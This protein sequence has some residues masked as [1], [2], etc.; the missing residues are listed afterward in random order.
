MF[1][2]KKNQLSKIIKTI[3]EDAYIYKPANKIF[4]GDK[5]KTAGNYRS[6]VNSLNKFIVKKYQDYIEKIENERSRIDFKSGGAISIWY[7]PLSPFPSSMDPYYMSITLYGP[8][9]DQIKELDCR[10]GK[11][12]D[13]KEGWTYDEKTLQWFNSQQAAD[14]LIKKAISSM[15]FK[16]VLGK[17]KLI[18]N[19]DFNEVIYFLKSTKYKKNNVDRYSG[20]TAYTVYNEDYDLFTWDISPLYRK[21]KKQIVQKLILDNQENLSKVFFSKISI[22]RIQNVSFN[23]NFLSVKVKTTTSLD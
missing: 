3:K 19:L 2:K 7:G 16:T 8:N 13:G 20:G 17:R 18:K 5:T 9:S 4:T 11:N 10:I 15:E 21:F 14:F 23:G 6:L 1:V 12:S 22:H